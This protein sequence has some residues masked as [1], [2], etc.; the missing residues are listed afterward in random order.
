[1]PPT[2]NTS[3]QMPMMVVGPALALAGFAVWTVFSLLPGLT[4]PSGAFR[5]REAW[6]TG[7]FWMVGVPLIGIAQLVAGAIGAGGL[8]RQPLWTLGGFFAGLLAVHPKGNDF[9]LLPL[10][11]IFVGVPSY[12]A[13]LGIAWLGRKLRGLLS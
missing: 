2:A 3:Q 7:A 5:I 4:Q 9:G 8:L 11:V 10:A 12:L 1:M 6:D 13:L